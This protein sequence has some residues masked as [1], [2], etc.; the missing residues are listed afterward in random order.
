MSKYRKFTSSDI[1]KMQSLGR[2]LGSGRDYKP[3]ITVRDVPS[4]GFSFRILG[5]KTQRKHHLLSKVELSFFYTLELDQNVIDIYEKYPLLPISETIK[6]AL[7][8]NKRHPYCKRKQEFVVMWTDFLVKINTA[9]EERF[10]AYNVKPSTSKNSKLAINNISIEK[11]YWENRGVEFKVKYADEVS[12]VFASNFK[13]IW[14]TKS[15]KVAPGLLEEDIFQAENL[16]YEHVCKSE[17]SISDIC[18]EVDD[19]LKFPPGSSLW[20]VKHL[21]ANSYWLVDMEKPIDT[22]ES[23]NFIRNTNLLLGKVMNN[24]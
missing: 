5:S 12:D 20:I 13:S 16:L 1:P 23:L 7:E 22:Y 19:E 21:I 17:N 18:N 14:R 10:I 11:K 4:K 6:N 3:W 2:G 24:E 9:G 8:G 15:L